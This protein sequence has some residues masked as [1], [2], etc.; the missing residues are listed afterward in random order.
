MSFRAKLIGAGALTSLMLA[1]LLGMTLFSYHGLGTGFEEIIL[2]AR[3]GVENSAQTEVQVT[4]ADDTL[5]AISGA[6]I[7]LTQDI[8]LAN[9]AVRINERKIARLGDTLGDLIEMIE[10]SAGEL[11]D[12]EARWALEDVSDEIGNIREIVRRE[13]LIGLTS[14]VKEMDRFTVVLDQQVTAVGALSNDL[15]TSRQL[16]GEVSIANQ[17]IQEKSA[18]FGQEISLTRN[19]FAATVGIMML[20]I[21]VGSFF[22]ARS[23]TNPINRIIQSLTCSS[24]QVTSASAQISKSSDSLAQG[25]YQQA[26]SIEKTSTSLSEITAQTNQNNV[27]AQDANETTASVSQVT[28]AC[29]L[30]MKR[31]MEAIEEILNSTSETVNIVKTIDEIAFQ[32]NL[33]ALNSA[34]E[35]ARAGDAGKGFAVVAEEVR[36]L[37]QRSSDAASNTAQLVERSR[38]SAVTVSEL[39]SSLANDF[40]EVSG[41]V[42]EV[43]KLI[44]DI[45]RQSTEQAHSISEINNSVSSIDSI[46]HQNAAT[47]EES[48]GAA[49]ELISMSR[50]MCEVISSLVA[51]AEGKQRD[52]LMEAGSKQ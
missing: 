1:A 23:I 31:L 52:E 35:A 38:A 36:N 33:L 44:S 2:D 28:N 21:M 13:A 42:S 40:D 43:E 39:A 10:E 30:A 4:A 8:V 12:D 24:S 32:T 11:P 27:T 5:T 25:S 50:A 45:A 41:G 14:T 20:L 18:R 51:L 47:S 7:G 16:S 49:Q 19:I 22:F 6:M 34:V 48:A 46:V 37:A 26:A 9:N 29:S 3:T 15:S 17:S